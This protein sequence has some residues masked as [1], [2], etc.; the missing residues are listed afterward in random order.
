MWEKRVCMYS[1]KI[2]GS[3]SWEK[4][5]RKKEKGK[6]QKGNFIIGKKKS[7]VIQKKKER[8]NLLMN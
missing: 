5:E 4:K 6:S 2:V 1:E 3:Y 8:K 7:Y